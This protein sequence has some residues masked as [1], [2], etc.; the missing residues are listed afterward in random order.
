MVELCQGFYLFPVT[1]PAFKQLPRGRAITHTC[2]TEAEK[3]IRKEGLFLRGRRSRARGRAIT[4]T[5]RTEAEKVI[6]KEGL[7]LRGRRSRARGRAI[8]H[9]QNRG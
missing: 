4:H 2:R 1:V 8:T 3:V 6:R 9:V 5:C 7:F